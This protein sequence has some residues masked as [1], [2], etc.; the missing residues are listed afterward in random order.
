[1]DRP[2]TDREH[3]ALD[4]LLAIDFPDA[5]RYR[6]QAD[7]VRVVDVCG[8]GCPSIDFYKRSD[9]GMSILVNAGVRGSYDGIEYVSNSDQIATGL[10]A[11][12]EL[13]IEASGGRVGR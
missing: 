3:A 1:M 9:I 11:P 12:S 13:E 4:A 5:D 2:L 6:N 8:C 7:D 10:P